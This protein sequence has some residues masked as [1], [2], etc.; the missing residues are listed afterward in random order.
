[1]MRIGD[2][3]DANPTACWWFR[4]PILKFTTENFVAILVTIQSRT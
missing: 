4:L 2:W 1:M 3:A